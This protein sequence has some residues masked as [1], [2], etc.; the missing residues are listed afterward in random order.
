MESRSFIIEG[1]ALFLFLIEATA[2]EGLST[3]PR[4]D[5]KEMFH[6]IHVTLKCFDVPSLECSK[7]EFNALLKY[8]QRFL[9]ALVNV[10]RKK[11]LIT[12]LSCYTC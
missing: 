10:A 1:L 2:A 12:D 3:T 6:N 11:K 5:T 9:L 7:G 8:V 4:S